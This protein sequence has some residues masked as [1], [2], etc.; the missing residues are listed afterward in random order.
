MYWIYTFSCVQSKQFW[1][2][3]YI[4]N[5]NSLILELEIRVTNHHLSFYEY[6]QP[7]LEGGWTRF[8]IE[9]VWNSAAK[10]IFNVGSDF[11]DLNF[12]QNL[13]YVICLNTTLEP[14]LDHG[15]FEPCIIWNNICWL[16]V[17]FEIRSEEASRQ[18]LRDNL[19]FSLNLKQNSCI[20]SWS[21]D[22]YQIRKFD[23]RVQSTKMLQS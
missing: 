20:R 21:S 4:R 1:R 16:G 12:K 9:E 3:W 23:P 10:E 17:L 19:P 11:F 15:L 13:C 14:V 18:N 6:H 8:I 2:F 7:R 22:D 5:R